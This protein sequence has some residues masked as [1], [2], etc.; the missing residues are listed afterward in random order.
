MVELKLGQQLVMTPQLQ[1]AIR[2]LGLPLPKLLLELP[3]MVKKAPPLETIAR[4]VGDTG[5]EVCVSND[6]VVTANDAYPT[7]SIYGAHVPLTFE[8]P[9]DEDADSDL[10]PKGHTPEEIAFARDAMWLLRAIR[11]RA[12]S[13]VKLGRALVALS[14]PGV[15][16][17][18]GVEPTKI[19]LRA[20]AEAVGMHEST[21]S[22][23]TSAD[24][25]LRTPRG[26]LTFASFVN[27]R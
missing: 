23:M 12:R 3:E 10:M 25:T 13:F 6:L 7:F 21:L 9:A 1:M 5:F 26:D 18:E 16:T 22:R 20:V 4:E 8:P 17:D 11:Q 27:A 19:K 15:F 2:L 14:P 24:Q